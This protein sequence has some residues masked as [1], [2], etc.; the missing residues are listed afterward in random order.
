MNENTI[1]LKAGISLLISNGL[2]YE[3]ME[4][5]VR[6]LLDLDYQRVVET[7]ISTFRGMIRFS[8]DV[9]LISVYLHSVVFLITRFL[10]T[11]P[12]ALT[13]VSA[14]YAKNRDCS[15]DIRPIG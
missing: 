11:L 10:C 2:E 13:Y 6:H 9:Q 3:I 7:K 8:P 1:F 12:L 5:R 14:N 4:P 15:L